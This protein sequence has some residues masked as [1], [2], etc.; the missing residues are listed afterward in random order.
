MPGEQERAK[1]EAP[2]PQLDREDQLSPARSL[3]ESAARGGGQR[4]GNNGPLANPEVSFPAEPKPQSENDDE[5][6]D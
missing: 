2:A 1:P 4:I 3:R 6:P 5:T